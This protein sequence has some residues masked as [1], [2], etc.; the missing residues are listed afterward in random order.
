MFHLGFFNPVLGGDPISVPALVLVLLAP[1]RVHHD[2]AGHGCDQRNHSHVRA[3]TDFWL[4]LYRRLEYRHR[5]DR[6]LRL[7][8]PHVSDRRVGIRRADLLAAQLSGRDS[9]GGQGFQLDLDALQR[10]DLLGHADALRSRLHRLV[11]DRRPY[12]LVPGLPR[13]GH[14]YPRHLLRGRPLPLHHGGRRGNGLRRRTALLVAE[15]HRPALP[16]SSWRVSRR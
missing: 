6:L 7:G 15:N 2:F 12:R 16:R 10:L 11:P 9:L 13:P 5:G 8:S 1:G 4:H 3:Q 14:S